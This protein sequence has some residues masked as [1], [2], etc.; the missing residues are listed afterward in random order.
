MAAVTGQRTVL[1][2]AQEQ[3]VIDQHPKLLLLEPDAAPLTVVSKTLAAKGGSKPARDSTF[4]WDEDELAVRFDAINK[5]GGHT[6][7]ETELTVDTEAVFYAGSLVRVPRTG[8]TMYVTAV[9]SNKITVTRG[10]AGTEEAALNDNEPIC[11]LGGVSEEGVTSPVA[12][13]GNPVQR[14]NYTEITRTSVDATGTL[15]SSSNE[16]TPH[17]WAYQHKKGFIEHLKSLEY[18][19]LHGTPSN[20]HS[21]PN[22]K[23]V[24]TTG[25]L[26]HYCTQN[27]QDAG[28][29]LTETEFETWVRALSRYS[30]GQ[31]WVFCSPLVISVINSY[32]VGKLETVTNA[33][34]YGVRVMEY[35]SPHGSMKLVRHDLLEGATW[36]GMAIAVD[37]KIG[38]FKYKPLGGPGSPKGSRDTKLRTNIQAP[39]YD[40]QK[41]EW[42]TECGWQIAQPRAHGVLS[43]VT[44]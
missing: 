37:F 11:V 10:F 31:K 13:T 15:L 32:A 41:D 30:G 17:D 1:N 19:A 3:R 29:A 23:R 5:E 38:D 20:T 35:I 25:G 14:T 39:D 16:T 9:G 26:L 27:H 8:E 42:L 43:G 6:A 24:R 7:E 12:R 34:T 44:G 4:H 2:I 18:K 21:G 33:S 36:G 22:G 40:G 28:G